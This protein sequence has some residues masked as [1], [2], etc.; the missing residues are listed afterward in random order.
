MSST[1]HKQSIH[2][3]AIRWYWRLQQM[4]AEHPDR[5]RFE[6]WLMA[7]ASHQ[8]DYGEVE[9]MWRKLDSTSQIQQLAAA[10]DKMHAMQSRSKLKSL[11]STLSV[12]VILTV[13]LFG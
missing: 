12:A 6:A 5:S 4:D 9:K 7:D 13:G 8:H 3:T 11:A 2:D 10:M 1:S